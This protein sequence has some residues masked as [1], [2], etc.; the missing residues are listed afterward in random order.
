MNPFRLAGHTSAYGPIIADRA[1]PTPPGMRV[2]TGRFQQLRSWKSRSPQTIEPSKGQHALE[3]HP[4]VAPPASAVGPHP[5]GKP[6]LGSQRAVRVDGRATSALL[7]LEGA[8]PMTQPPVRLAPAPGCLRQSDVRLPTQQT[9]PRPV[10]HSAHAAPAAVAHQ[11]VAVGT[12]I[13]PRPPHR[14]V[15][16]ALPHTAPALSHD[17]KALARVR[18]KYPSEGKEARDDSPEPGPGHPTMLTTPP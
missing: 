4:A 17:A 6:G 12:R 9:G 18:M 14:S 16:A 11:S 10:H 8:R 2:C 15:R 1:P 5:S 13:A 7:D 3:Q